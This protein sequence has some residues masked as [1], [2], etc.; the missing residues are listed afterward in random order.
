MAIAASTSLDRDFAYQYEQ[1]SEPLKA[2]ALVLG[3]GA[4]N[5]IVSML[6]DSTLHQSASATPDL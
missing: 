2:W 5:V 6:C 4:R 1:V 3:R